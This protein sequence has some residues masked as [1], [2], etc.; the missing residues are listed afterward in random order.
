MSELLARPQAPWSL[1]LL[2]PFPAIAQRVLALVGHEDLAIRE[3]GD[4]VKMDPSF[5]AELL[6][7]ANSAL[8]GVRHGVK[9]VSQAIVLLG[10]DRV[11]TMATLVAVNRMV[12]GSVRVES[13][14]KAW[15]HSLA[16]AVIAE[17]AARVSG[18]AIDTA[19]TAGLLHN[20]GTLGL[21]SAYPEEYSRMLEV[22]QDFGF[23]LLQTERDLFDI[24]HCLAGCYLA[25]DWDF[26]DELAAAIAVHHEDPVPG[27]ASLDN[28]VKVSWRLSDTLGYIAFPP[29]KPW[30][31]HE[32]VAFLPNSGSFARGKSPEE[33][34]AS[35]NHRLAAAP[36]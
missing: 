19:Y 21:M 5:S 28:V 31:Y 14:R 23:D 9:S 32:L 10:L 26:P 20:L 1:R 2:P 4:L 35:V 12:R 15:L 7:F 8:F 17:E 25:Q 33:F 18:V 22:T 3:L 11:K 6:H 30:S 24:D 16:T 27:E 36:V 13:L 29:D 34:K